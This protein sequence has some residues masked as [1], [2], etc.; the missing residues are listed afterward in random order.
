MANLASAGLC[1]PPSRQQTCCLYLRSLFVE[2]KA[3]G[4]SL[5]LRYL[6]TE[7]KSLLIE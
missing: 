6:R 2:S 5:L 3:V 1:E 7:R 4:H